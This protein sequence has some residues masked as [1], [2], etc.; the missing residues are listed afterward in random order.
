[1]VTFTGKTGQYLPLF[2]LGEYLHIGKGTTFGL[3]KYRMVEAVDQAGSRQR[4]VLPVVR[5]VQG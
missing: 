5:I 3:G 1:S 2:R 4:A